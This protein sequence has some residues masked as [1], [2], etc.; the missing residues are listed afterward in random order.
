MHMRQH[1]LFP[2][3]GHYLFLVLAIVSMLTTA[4]LT[5]SVTTQPSYSLDKQN[6]IGTLS[7]DPKIQTILSMINE[8]LLRTYLKTLVD[9]APRVTGTYGCQQTAS[10]IH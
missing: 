5:S 10:Y 7:P 2:I 4:T 8:T 9:Y 1:R 3:I 6:H